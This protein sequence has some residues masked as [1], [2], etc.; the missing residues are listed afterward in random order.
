MSPGG[1]DVSPVASSCPS[2]SPSSSTTSRRR[3]SPS[4]SLPARSTSAWRPS[5][6][7]MPGRRAA[8]EAEA[9]R[10]A[11]AALARIDANRTARAELLGVLGDAP[12]PWIGVPLADPSAEA[13]RA[14]GRRPGPPGCRSRPDRRP[15]GS[16]ARHPPR[17]GRHGQL[18]RRAWARSSPGAPG[19]P[20]RAG[21]TSPRPGA[22]A[23][24]RCSAMRPMKPPRSGIATSVLPP[25]RRAWPH[26][27]RRSWPP[28]SGSI[29][30]ERTRSSRSST[31]GSIRIGPSPI[32]RSPTG[33]I[34][35]RGRRSSS[36]R[37]RSSSRP[38]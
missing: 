5:S 1:R 35:G 32:I 4:R 9:S 17:P 24:S 22:S 33:C 34:A 25:L 7:T 29:S 12:L 6:S 23:G 19:E 16:G 15:A 14:V 30:S 28:S 26:R 10:L 18:G 3:R 27:S 13:G 20:R 37:A 11:G 31:G 8:A 2:P 38:T 21:E 36:A